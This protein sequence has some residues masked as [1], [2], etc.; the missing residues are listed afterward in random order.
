M[1]RSAVTSE[2]VGRVIDGR[3]ALQEWLG[4]SGGNGVFLTELPQPITKKAA[5][6]LIPAEGGEV[7]AYLARWAKI[8][9]LSHPHLMKVFRSGRFQFGSTGLV[10]VVTECADEVLSQILPERALTPEETREMLELVIDA[11]GYLHGKSFVHGHLKP[12]NI[13][14]VNDQLKLSADNVTAAGSL[15][16]RLQMPGVYDAPEATRGLIVPSADVWALGMTL[17]EVMTQRPPVW[18][19]GANREPVVAASMPRPFAEIA[20]ECL[21]RD[22]DQRPTLSEIKARLEPSR[23]I[24]FRVSKAEKPPAAAAPAPATAEILS[25]DEEASAAVGLKMRLL[26]LA[27]GVLVVLVVLGLL[28]MRGH[29]KPDAVPSAVG[30]NTGEVSAS[31]SVSAETGVTAKGAVAHRVVPDV[32]AFARHTIRGTVSMA[33]RVKADANGQVTDATFKS[34]GSSKYFERTA[35]DAAREW[36][37]KPPLKDG[38]PAE[39]AWLIHFKFRESGTETAAVE[40]TP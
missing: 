21:R 5:I 10:Y 23:P 25:T 2:W 29:S 31:G 33:I 16:D 40:E 1:S 9:N 24:E 27:G 39:S 15:R 36:K 14:V 4:G 26:P 35:L 6:K 12:S 34:G 32:P 37:F 28:L 7:D 30:Q 11:L 3:F 8:A 19:G 13:L 22:P 20:R 18:E 17:V 38:Q